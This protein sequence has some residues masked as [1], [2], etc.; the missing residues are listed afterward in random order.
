MRISIYRVDLVLDLLNGRIDTLEF[1]CARLVYNVSYAEQGICER[2]SAVVLSEVRAC[3][4]SELVEKLDRLCVESRGRVRN[5]SEREREIVVFLSVVKLV[6][7]VKA[8]VVFAKLFDYGTNVT[9]KVLI[10]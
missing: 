8:L 1:S 7:T 6:R 2:S 10:A 5:T 4:V 9:K 3:G